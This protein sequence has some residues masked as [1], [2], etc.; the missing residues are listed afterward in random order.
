VPQVR[1]QAD[2]LTSVPDQCGTWLPRGRRRCSW[3]LRT[4]PR[5]P[6]EEL[7]RRHARSYPWLKAATSAALFA[8][9]SARSGRRDVHIWIGPAGPAG[10]VLTTP[11]AEAL[12]LSLRSSEWTVRA[13]RTA[14][15]R[16]G[17]GSRGRGSVSVVDD[18]T[19]P[20][21][22]RHGEGHHER[23]RHAR[24]SP[25]TWPEPPG[26]PHPANMCGGIP[27]HG[28]ATPVTAGSSPKTVKG[29][30]HGDDKSGTD[31][32]R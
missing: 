25:V 12:A 14:E 29:Q 10:C 27:A 13:C 6:T 1:R 20:I 4:L 3:S 11:D 19:P 21:R 16:R 32:G 18:N 26:H 23:E 9:M 7:R 30:C 15:G 2:S 5:Q 17:P 22:N 8:A 24:R 28:Q 31:G